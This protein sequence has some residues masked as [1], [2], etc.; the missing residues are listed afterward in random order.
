[1]LCI[2]TLCLATRRAALNKHLAHPTPD[3]IVIL[4]QTHPDST[5]GILNPREGFERFQLQRHAPCP[6]L[7][8]FVERHWIIRWDLRDAAP[9][10]QETLPHPCA[11]M[12]FEGHMA[13]VH[14]VGLRR[15]V[16]TLD[17]VGLVVATKFKPGGLAP[18]S[19]VPMNKL[20]GSHADLAAVFSVDQDHA[21]RLAAEVMASRRDED[22]IQR[23]E[24]F[25]IARDPVDDPQAALAT[26]LVELA[27]GYQEIK[28]VEEL[29]ASAA[30]T[31]RTL[32]RLFS[33][34]VGVAPKWVIRRAR[35]Q[36]A[37]E[38]VAHGERVDW[39][40]LALELGYFDQA[41]FVRDFKA[42]TGRTPAEYAAQ[43]ATP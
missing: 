5:L 36:E 26:R 3:E 4:R 42:Q 7:A 24:A 20:A 43:C 9:F 40:A 31:T 12:V 16:A 33:R 22:A 14:G 18:F 39:A 27:R 35:V 41:H 15:F 30:M 38:R 11:N 19:A 17:G 37:A 1:M 34:Y 13:A 23:I 8:P 21:A 28:T 6:A 29:A 25:L 2:Y 32:Q 10:K